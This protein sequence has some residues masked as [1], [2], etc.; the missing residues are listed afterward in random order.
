MAAGW[1]Q[2]SISSISNIY[3]LEHIIG[4]TLVGYLYFYREEVG[5]K[6]CEG[7]SPSSYHSSECIIQLSHFKS[8]EATSLKDTMSLKVSSSSVNEYEVGGRSA[9]RTKR[10][11]SSATAAKKGVEQN[12]VPIDESEQDKIVEKLKFDAERQARNG[13]TTFNYLFLTIAVIFATC[14]LYS[15]FFPFEMEH[16]VLPCYNAVFSRLSAH[17]PILSYPYQVYYIT[18]ILRQ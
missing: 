1:V 5:K 16:E 7:L 2:I 10:T 13:R 6:T 3:K 4:H 8:A 17:S 15:I 11:S 12:S 14:L 9:P 18:I